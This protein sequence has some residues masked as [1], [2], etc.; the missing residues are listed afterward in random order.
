MASKSRIDELQ[1]KHTTL[2]DKLDQENHRP[3][4]DQAVITSLKREKLRLKDEIVHLQQGA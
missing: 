4:P 3:S 1:R 2:E